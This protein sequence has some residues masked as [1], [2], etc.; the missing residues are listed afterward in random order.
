MESRPGRY[1]RHMPER[2]PGGVSTD[3]D[4]RLSE[5]AEQGRTYRGRGR[6]GWRGGGV[7]LRGGRGARRGQC[8]SRGLP[9]TDLD[10]KHIDVP[11]WWE[12]RPEKLADRQ[13]IHSKAKVSR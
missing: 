12:S 9:E 11:G 4:V 8:V 10:L 6:V 13:E 2:G 1:E 5:R 7:G 3:I